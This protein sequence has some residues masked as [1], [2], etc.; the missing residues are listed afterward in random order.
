[1]DDIYSCF[2]A[3][4]SKSSPTDIC[5]SNTKADSD[6]DHLQANLARKLC[7]IAI[8]QEMG[9]RIHLVRVQ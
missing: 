9:K 4:S 5:S 8:Q 3:N 2:G 7:T 6:T 1:M